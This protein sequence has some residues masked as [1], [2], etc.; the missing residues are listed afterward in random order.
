MLARDFDQDGDLDV[1]A[2]SFFPD[3]KEV[4]EKGFVYLRQEKNLTFAA[5]TFAQSQLGHWLTME[6]GDY[7]QDGD[8]D[9]ILGSFTYTPAP[10]AWQEKWRSEGASLVVLQNQQVKKVEKAIALN[11]K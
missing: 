6:A 9:I 10:P 5:S 7:D 4:P 3:F 11:K 1:A 2:I 8:E